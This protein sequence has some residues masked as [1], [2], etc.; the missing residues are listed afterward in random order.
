MVVS[1]FVALMILFPIGMFAGEGKGQRGGARGGKGRRSVTPQ[2]QA[3][4]SASS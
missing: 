4:A 1:I 3:A 2:A